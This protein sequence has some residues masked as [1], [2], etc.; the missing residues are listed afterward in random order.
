[1]R[2]KLGLLLIV[3]FILSSCQIGGPSQANIK[4]NDDSLMT[5]TNKQLSQDEYFSLA[6]QLPSPEQDYTY[7]LTLN[8]FGGQSYNKTMEGE[9]A[10][11]G[12]DFHS[13]SFFSSKT[14]KSFYVASSDVYIDIDTGNTRSETV[15]DYGLYN[16]NLDYGAYLKTDNKEG[17]TEMSTVSNIPLNYPNP[18][19][20]IKVK[21]PE[22][23]YY[24][25]TRTYG[26]FVTYNNQGSPSI[27]WDQ[28]LVRTDSIRPIIY[29][30]DTGDYYEKRVQFSDIPVYSHSLTS[31]YLVIKEKRKGP[32]FGA[33]SPDMNLRYAYCVEMA[34]HKNYYFNTS[35]YFSYQTGLLEKVEGSFNTL[36]PLIEP[37]AEISAK[38]VI[39]YQNNTYESIKSKHI[40]YGNQFLNHP[41]IVTTRSE[42]NN[43]EQRYQSI[44]TLLFIIE[45]TDFLQ[46]Y[47]FIIDIKVWYSSKEYSIRS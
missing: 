4:L 14:G 18:V 38:Y 28:S 2:H 16:N 13:A 29:T 3:F 35:Y 45:Q 12:K 37:L 19:S 31:N 11:K 8:K 36:D 15:F 17:W 27:H 5:L 20:E 23:D 21:T 30:F 6:E 26:L 24:S 25:M 47:I 7:K 22:K 32:G 1:M 43:Q 39:T 10:R 46:Y 44:N 33:V 40:E 34:N 42:Y 9:Y 41:G